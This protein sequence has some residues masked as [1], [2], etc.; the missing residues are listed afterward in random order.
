M[1]LIH[2]LVSFADLNIFFNQ[3]FSLLVVE[4]KGVRNL[5]WIFFAILDFF[6]FFAVDHVLRDAR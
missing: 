4:R 5:G 1:C 3:L 6:L 2:L